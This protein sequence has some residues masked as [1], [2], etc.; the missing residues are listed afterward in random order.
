MPGR[1]VFAVKAVNT[2]AGPAGLLLKS[3]VRLAD[4]EAIELNS[5]EAWKCSLIEQSNWQQLAFEDGQ[6]SA[7]RVVAE[8]W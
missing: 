1:N 6:W 2:L 8:V 4:G 5:D 7:V 3:V